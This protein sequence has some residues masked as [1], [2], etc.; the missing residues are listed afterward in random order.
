MK[1]LIADDNHVMRMALA[2]IL[3]KEKNWRVI[4][5]SDGQEAWAEGI[6]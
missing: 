5:T 4:E 1:I 6:G 3:T 2:D